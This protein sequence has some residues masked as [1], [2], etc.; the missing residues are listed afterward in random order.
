M[1]LAI[2]FLYTT[3][4][5]VCF[6]GS[7][8]WMAPAC[9]APATVLETVSDHQT[10]LTVLSPQLAGYVRDD[11]SLWHAFNEGVM[12]WIDR[13]RVQ[14]WG[15]L[16]K[17]G[18]RVWI[19]TGSP[20]IIDVPTAGAVLATSNYRVRTANQ[21]GC[22]VGVLQSDPQA[23]RSR[24]GL[25]HARP[26]HRSHF[27]GFERARV[28]PFGAI[29]SASDFLSDLAGDSS[30]Y[31]PV[32]TILFTG[33]SGQEAR[34]LAGKIV[35]LHG[36]ES[37]AALRWFQVKSGLELVGVDHES[38]PRAL[39]AATWTLAEPDRVVAVTIFLGSDDM[40]DL[41]DMPDND[42][43]LKWL[44]SDHVRLTTVQ[45]DGRWIQ[46]VLALPVPL[47]QE[48]VARIPS[49]MAASISQVYYPDAAT[50]I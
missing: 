47:R 12:F 37:F 1:K 14:D 38:L 31:P 25:I 48:G 30:N 49:A 22:A 9:L 21:Q 17:H 34:E 5:T 29:P 4:T 33:A 18:F 3:L 7:V 41:Q 43:A 10:L 23:S 39:T 40:V 35:H 28:I 27:V 26:T 19:K 13:H 36:E 16:A 2:L 24:L 46:K 8:P 44:I 45:L 6:C 15:D 11:D 42:L 20:N 32:G 50:F